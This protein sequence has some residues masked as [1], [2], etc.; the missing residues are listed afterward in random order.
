M[1]FPQA[2]LEA[3]LPIT[4]RTAN[5]DGVERIDIGLAAGMR[6]LRSIQKSRLARTGAIHGGRNGSSFPRRGSPLASARASVG[7]F[8]AVVEAVGT[9]AGFTTEGEEV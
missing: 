4:G 9:F 5:A 2:V 8:R 3:V 7:C 6:A 1:V